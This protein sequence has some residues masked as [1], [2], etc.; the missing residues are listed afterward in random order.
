[1]KLAASVDRSFSPSVV[2]STARRRDCFT[3]DWYHS[4]SDFVIK[5]VLWVLTG[6][7]VCFYPKKTNLTCSVGTMA[8]CNQWVGELE[9]DRLGRAYVFLNKVW[10]HGFDLLVQPPDVWLPQSHKAMPYIN[11]PY[12]TRPKWMDFFSSYVDP[13]EDSSPHTDFVVDLAPF[14]S[15]ILP[16]GRVVFPL[17][18]R[19][20]SIRMADRDFRPD[21]I[22]YAS[23]YTQK[24]DF[25]EDSTSYATPGEAEL[26]N[27]ASERDRTVGFIGFV[28]PGVGQYSFSRTIVCPLSEVLITGAIPPIAEMQAMWW[29]SLI[30]GEIKTPLSAPHYHLLVK[31]NARIKYGV[32]HSTY[33]STLAKDIHAAPGLWQLW[34]EY[35]THVLICYWYVVFS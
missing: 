35:G 5:R 24:F 15:H 7:D 8:G 29:T 4:V 33:I 16:S 2:V 18:K 14:P 32:D 30:K 13:V 6:E 28:R 23:G 31:E 25:F 20:D 21:T 11:R 26:R 17:S 19:K 34:R 27:V 1:M 22:I 12:R 10:I 9:P 3:P